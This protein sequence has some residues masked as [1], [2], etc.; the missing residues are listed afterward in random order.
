MCI[1]QIP[2]CSPV[3]SGVQMRYV[4]SLHPRIHGD[5]SDDA[6]PAL[7]FPPEIHVNGRFKVAD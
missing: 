4:I 2:A 1:Q 3:S 7:L 6:F 5:N